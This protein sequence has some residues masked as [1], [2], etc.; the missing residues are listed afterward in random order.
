MF[1]L[2][3]LSNQNF[4]LVSHLCCTCVVRLALVSHLCHTC[5][6]RFSLVLHF[7]YLCC[8]RV[9]LVSLLSG[10]CFVNQTRSTLTYCDCKSF[11]VTLKLIF[12]SFQNIKVRLSS[13][14]KFFIIYFNDG[15]SKMLKN[16]FYF[17]L[18]ALFV[19]KIFKFLSWLF[20]HVEKRLER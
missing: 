9:T 11:I 3:W 15:P 17:I 6:S 5:V 10:A 18:K 16:A 14:K 7:C 12:S 20:G 4:S 8:T 2:V 1:L 13:F 19:L